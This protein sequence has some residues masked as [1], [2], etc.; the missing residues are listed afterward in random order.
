MP[1]SRE[2]ILYTDDHL[3]AVNKLSA[4]LV[5]AGRGR[6]DRLPLLDFLREDYPGIRPLHRL[7]FETSCVV[8]FARTKRTLETVLAS[9]SVGWKK[10]YRMLIIGAPHPS[11]GTIH[12]PLEPRS[13]EWT[14][15]AE[16]A[17]KLLDVFGPVAYMEA[18]IER[19]QFHQIRR[20]FAGIKHPLVL[21]DDHGDHKF[22]KLFAGTFKYR[23]FFLH[24]VRIEFTH[25]IT[26]EPMAISAPLPRQFNDVL[27]QMR[28]RVEEMKRANTRK[29]RRG[30]KK[31]P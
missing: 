20:H 29:P 3:L 4:E 17:Y 18:T 26:G 23:R 16:T 27:D 21:D 1:I 8:V 22:N 30:P 15:K 19:G 11:S 2:R 14:V 9:K 10:T 7:D 5:V 12:I 25:P 24:A 28:K 31:K 13:G 6:L